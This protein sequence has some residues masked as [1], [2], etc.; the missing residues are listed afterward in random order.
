MLFIIST[1]CLSDIH[2]K[3]WHNDRK[4]IT[5]IFCL[6]T[7]TL[8]DRENTTKW[9]Y[10]AQFLYIDLTVSLISDNDSNAQ[11]IYLL[12]YVWLILYDGDDYSGVGRH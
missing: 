10:F 7:E 11:I 12:L 9:L 2:S 3:T 8:S 6:K 5:T 1:D 4:Q